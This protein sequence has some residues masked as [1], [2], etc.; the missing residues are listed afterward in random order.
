M[1]TLTAPAPA[2]SWVARFTDLAMPAGHCEPLP[3][4]VDLVGSH[5]EVLFR[6]AAWLLADRHA[7]FARVELSDTSV[8]C[9]LSAGDPSPSLWVW[10]E[11]VTTSV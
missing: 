8:A 11:P 4:G 2:L 7:P 9:Y 6:V 5:D 1:F 10:V 3:T